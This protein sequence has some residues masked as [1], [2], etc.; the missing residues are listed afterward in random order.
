[1]HSTIRTRGRRRRRG[2]LLLL[3]LFM[4]AVTSTIVLGVITSNTSQ[5]AALRNS[6]DYERA[7]YVAGAG[8]H[9]ALAKLEAD[10]NWR[11]GLSSVAFPS[12]SSDSYS[13]TVVDGEG[14]EVT[15]TSTGTAGQVTRKL[16]VTVELGG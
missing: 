1:M 4:M 2:G 12:G 15:I 13:V 11:N 16:E 14:D 10:S 5:L 7:L 6:A 8:I 9:H 3:V